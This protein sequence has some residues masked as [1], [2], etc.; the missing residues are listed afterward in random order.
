MQNVELNGKTRSSLKLMLK[1]GIGLILIFAIYL[2]ILINKNKQSTKDIYIEFLIYWLQK[3]K[4]LEP[5][6]MRLF[7]KNKN[8]D[9]FFE[10]LKQLPT[11]S[12]ARLLNKIYK[13]ICINRDLSTLKEFVKLL[14][15]YKISKFQ[16]K[17][18]FTWTKGDTYFW[19]EFDSLFSEKEQKPLS[20]ITIKQKINKEKNK[21][22]EEN[23]IE[24]KNE[25]KDEV[26]N[27]IEDEV[28]VENELETENE[29]KDTNIS[30]KN[31]NK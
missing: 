16:W 24:V 11:C 23:E 7:I 1:I 22:K 12:S 8:L 19:N 29:N 25:I 18:A 17:N 15:K 3:T 27:E 4:Y 10:S 9:D 2:I 26:K 14:K 21:N 30:I 13:E 20:T 28:E 5:M 6:E 31:L